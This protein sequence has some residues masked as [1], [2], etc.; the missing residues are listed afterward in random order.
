MRCRL[1]SVTR[2]NRTHFHRAIVA[3][4]DV[5]MIL[6]AGDQQESAHITVGAY[7]STS[8]VTPVV[9][10]NIVSGQVK[11]D[12]GWHKG[13]QVDSGTFLPQ[14]GILT[15]RSHTRKGGADDLASGIDRSRY[16]AVTTP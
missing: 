16:T 9:D 12:A 3:A 13:I 10:V 11:I 4:L 15:T 1:G 14:G 8:D 2:S 5:R 7:G 6:V